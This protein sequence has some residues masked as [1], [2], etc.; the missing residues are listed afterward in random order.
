MASKHQIMV[1]G[2]VIGGGAPVVV[3]SMTTTETSDVGAALGQVGRLA[4]AGCEVVRVAV[5]GRADADALPAIVAG[6]VLPV[7]ADIHFNSSLALRALD[8]GVAAVRINPGNIGGADKV[9]QV[10]TRAK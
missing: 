9:E 5:P 4:E 10:V 3:Q 8:A 1:G 7:I 6:S 2:V